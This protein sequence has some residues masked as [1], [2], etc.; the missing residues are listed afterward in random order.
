LKSVGIDNFEYM[1]YRL[2]K[3]WSGVPPDI[4]ELKNYLKPIFEWLNQNTKKGD[5]V[6]IQGDFGA[7]CL[8]VDFCFQKGFVPV[9][10]TTKRNTV[11]K[12]ENG[13]LIKVS[14]FEHVR[15]R[16]YERL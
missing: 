12:M 4:E 13:K 14:E 10:A 3:L 6:L 5:W 8:M 15:F 11:E 7:V 16:R 1:P 9:Y 2:Q